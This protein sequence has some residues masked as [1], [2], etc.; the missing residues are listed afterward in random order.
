[1]SVVDVIKRREIPVI[2]AAVLLILT[3]LGSYFGGTIINPINSFIAMLKE[4]AM[5]I[6]AWTIGLALVR[7]FQ[8]EASVVKRREKWWIFSAYSIFFTLLTAALAFVPPFMNNL[9]YNFVLLTV[10]GYGDGTLWSFVLWSVVAASARAFR[11]RSFEMGVLVFIIMVWFLYY[12]PYPWAG[13][14]LFDIAMFNQNSMLIPG[15][16]AFLLLEGLAVLGVCFRTMIG[17]ERGYFR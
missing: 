16:R 12:I 14:T 10:V 8:Y 7:M 11:I 15:N 9:P 6:T 17:R 2:I 3:S 13:N 4:W 5:I 1:M